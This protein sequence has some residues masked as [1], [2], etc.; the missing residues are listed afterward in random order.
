MWN[1][2]FT[3]LQR[4]TQLN[5]E[6]RNSVFEKNLIKV[7]TAFMQQR[8]T[9]SSSPR[10]SL[11]TYSKLHLPK[12]NQQTYTPSYWLSCPHRV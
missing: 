9:K 1:F 3:D 2:G 6:R 5:R 11:R 12:I 7:D 8:E 4:V 10:K